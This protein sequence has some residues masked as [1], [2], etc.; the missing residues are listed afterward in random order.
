MG[1]RIKKRTGKIEWQHGEIV[2]EGAGAQH[3][4]CDAGLQRAPTPRVAH[5][6]ATKSGAYALK[7]APLVVTSN[8]NDCRFV[9][10]HI[11]PCRAPQDPK[12]LSGFGS[13][14]QDASCIQLVPS[15]VR[16][17][18]SRSFARPLSSLAHPFGFK[19]PSRF[20]GDPRTP[21]VYTRCLSFVL[22]S[23]F[24]RPR[25]LTFRA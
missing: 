16:G 25:P 13:V 3:F 7:A 21:A 11:R 2:P 17:R 23:Q 19:T 9:G 8:H 6:A 24:A 20:R 5:A 12:T 22:L 4:G 15:C 1:G 14:V 18:W 10:Y